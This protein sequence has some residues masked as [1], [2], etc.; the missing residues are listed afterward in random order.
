M[1]E[2]DLPLETAFEQKFPCMALVRGID[3]CVDEADC[4]AFHIGQ[5]E[6]VERILHICR[7]ERSDDRAVRA[8]SFANAEPERSSHK[9]FRRPPEDVVHGSPV[10]A[11]DLEDVAKARRRQQADRRTLSLKDSIETGR[12]RVDEVTRLVQGLSVTGSP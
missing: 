3:V 12:R 8:H 4:D 6:R 10:A 7:L 1:R 9:G 5:S 2:R 11:S